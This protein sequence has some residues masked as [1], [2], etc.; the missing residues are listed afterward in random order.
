MN[1]VIG[2]RLLIP[3]RTIISLNGKK[4]LSFEL[5]IRNLSVDVSPAGHQGQSA[6]DFGRSSPGLCT[7]SFKVQ[8]LRILKFVF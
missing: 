5:D 8:Q 2:M 1:N 4:D 6:L 7:L 3:K